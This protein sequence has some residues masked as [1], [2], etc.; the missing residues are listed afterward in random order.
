MILFEFAIVSGNPSLLFSQNMTLINSDMS[1][2]FYAGPSLPREDRDF[3]RISEVSIHGWCFASRCAMWQLTTWCCRLH[4]TPSVFAKCESDYNFVMIF[5][6]M[7]WQKSW[8]LG[9]YV[10]SLGKRQ[11]LNCCIICCFTSHVWKAKLA[12]HVKC[13]FQI[14]W[15]DIVNTPCSTVRIL[16]KDISYI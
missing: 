15:S 8:C 6:A 12:Y 1:V 10:V 13:Q 4:S 14:F 7:H 16:A 5:V 2:F 3:N 9:R 11:E